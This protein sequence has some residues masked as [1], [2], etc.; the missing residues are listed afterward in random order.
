MYKYYT[1]L[2]KVLLNTDDITLEQLK[3]VDKLYRFKQTDLQVLAGFIEPILQPPT[4]IQSKTPRRQDC[5]SS[6]L[7]KDQHRSED[8]QKSAPNFF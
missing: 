3:S 2:L 5:F 8:T 4:Q 1:K 6:L 7:R